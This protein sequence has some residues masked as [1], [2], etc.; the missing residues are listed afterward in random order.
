MSIPILTSSFTVRRASNIDGDSGDPLTFEDVATGI[1]GTTMFYSGSASTA[2]GQ[3]ERVDCRIALT[4]GVYDVQEYDYVRDES[5][6]DE[7]R[8]AWV[9]T[10]E[11]L[12]LDHLLIGCYEITGVAR[13]TRDL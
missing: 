4:P 1:K 9:R 12:G 13:G 5:T 10:R 3:R 2:H 7:W 6:G 11:G 8:V